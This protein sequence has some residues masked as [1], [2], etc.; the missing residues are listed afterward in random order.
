MLVICSACALTVDVI[1]D[2]ME[3]NEQP[4]TSKSQITQIVYDA[5]GEERVS[6]L[7]NYSSDNGDKGLMEYLSPSRIEGMK[8]LMLN[9]GDD[10]WFYSPRTARIRKIASHQ[11]NQSVNNSDFSYEDLSTKDRREEYDCILSGEE[12]KNSIPCYRIEM[13]AKTKDKIYSK[14]I[15]WIDK[16][17]F[18]GI[19][20]Q[21]YDE[22]GTLWKQLF[23]KEIVKINAYWT[24]QYIEMRNVL[25]GSKT[26]MKMDNIEYD[27]PLDEALFSARN[28]KK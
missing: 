26:V 11:K 23:L 9:D 18:V 13:N 27:I 2:K 25:K 8:I 12:E 17:R 5:S 4:K 10:I 21:F 3:H 15:F 1:L 7:I 6:K 14:I 28:L 22:N 16:E 19:E 24:P 20:G